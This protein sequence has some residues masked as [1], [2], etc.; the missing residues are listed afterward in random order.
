MIHRRQTST[1]DGGASA[2]FTVD[3]STGHAM[4]DSPAEAEPMIDSQTAERP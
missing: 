4:I 1:V 2:A 3:R